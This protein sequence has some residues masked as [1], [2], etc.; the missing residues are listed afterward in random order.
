[1]FLNWITLPYLLINPV[2]IPLSIAQSETILAQEVS[3]PNYQKLVQY[4]QNQQLDRLAMADIIQN[5]ATQFLGAKYQAGLLDRSATEKLF[6]SLKEF[7]CVLFV[8]TVLALSH[9]FALKNY[10]YSA[11]S[12]Q[13]L[14]QR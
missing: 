5:I 4:A 8:E 6:I 13:V 3:D 14:N 7:D 12:Q 10:Q 11:F 9:N 2:L 1:M